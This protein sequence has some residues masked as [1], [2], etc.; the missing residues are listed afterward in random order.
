[1]ILYSVY[2]IILII[3]LLYLRF[4][5]VYKFWILQPVFHFYDFH[6]YYSNPQII[7]SSLPSITKYVDFI[8]I[9]SNNFENVIESEIQKCLF[10]IKNYYYRD[11]FCIFNPE[12]INFLPYFKGHNSCCFM[13][14]YWHKDLYRDKNSHIFDH[15]KVIGV[16]TS[17]P[18]S[19]KIN[20]EKF[21][22]YYVD[23]LCVHKNYRKKGIAPKLIQTHEYFQRHNNLKISTSF[24]KREGE[25]TG[26]VPLCYYQTHCYKINDI[27]VFN[28]LDP[29]VKMIAVDRQ[30]IQYL[31]HFIDEITHYQSIIHTELANIISLIETKNLLIYISIQNNVLLSAFFY[32]KTCVYYGNKEL[33]SLFAS[34]KSSDLSTNHFFDHFQFSLSTYFFGNQHISIEEIGDNNLL[35][36]MITKN[37]IISTSP[38]AYF[39]YNYIAQP[40]KAEKVLII[41]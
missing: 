26:I 23:Y 8:S 31:I 18:I 3:A 13:S 14:V 39:L 33:F 15:Q 12:I 30:N 11:N 1:M 28:K 27:L 21:N 35:T 34:I 2:F 24:F 22:S 32:R 37:L 19:I 4:K 40:I 6:Y 16:I 7:K 10:L 9:K 38:T 5:F 41:L 20:N 17:R 36:K 29:G 25:L